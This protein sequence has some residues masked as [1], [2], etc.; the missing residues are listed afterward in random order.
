MYS[1]P[2]GI[3]SR[4][5]Y[6]SLP[7]PFPTRIF[8][9]GKYNDPLRA[10]E[11]GADLFFFHLLA[12]G[13]LLGLI[14]GPTYM[15]GSKIWVPRP[16]ATVSARMLQYAE[17]LEHYFANEPFD[18]ADRQHVPSEADSANLYT[19]TMEKSRWIMGQTLDEPER[20]TLLSVGL[21]RQ[22]L[23]PAHVS[24]GSERQG[25]QNEGTKGTWEGCGG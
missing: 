11:S 10:E 20:L 8:H 2:H 24:T 7:V 16:Y 4:A 5:R 6:R 23:L 15:T 18:T 22:V 12:G 19:L 14:G 25:S 21:V 3:H 9:K 1:A 13:A 17:D